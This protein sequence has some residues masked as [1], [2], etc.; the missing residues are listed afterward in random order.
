MA[1]ISHVEVA[2]TTVAVTPLDAPIPPL[3]AVVVEDDTWGVLGADLELD[4]ES[5]G[6]D[7]ALENLAGFDPHT[8][9]SVLLRE[10]QPLELRAVVHDL[11]RNPTL[12]ETWVTT[13]LTRVFQVA[14]DRALDTMAMPL[15]GTV[16]GRLEGERAVALLVEALEGSRHGRPR[17]LWLAVHRQDVRETLA[18]LNASVRG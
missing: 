2:G 10:G 13:A 4:E 1:R 18:L 17:R 7:D 3:D 14:E 11:D 6:L 5:G 8:P 9:G 15:L 12:Q 16:H